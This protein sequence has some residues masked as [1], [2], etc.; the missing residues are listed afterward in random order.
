MGL[1][2][3]QTK[4]VEMFDLRESAFEKKFHGLSLREIQ[5][6]AKKISEIYNDLTETRKRTLEKSHRREKTRCGAR[7][8]RR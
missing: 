8:L 5:E 7:F 2:E 4:L 3:L 6:E 1:D